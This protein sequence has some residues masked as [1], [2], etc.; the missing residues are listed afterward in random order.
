MDAGARTLLALGFLLAALGVPS[1][2]AAAYDIKAEL[3]YMP[4]TASGINARYAVQIRNAGPAIPG[5]FQV[6]FWLTIPEGVKVV[7]WVINFNFQCT[8]APPF[9]GAVTVACS[10]S[11]PSVW[12]TGA[13]LSNQVFYAFNARDVK[14]KVCVIRSQVLLPN[15][16]GTYQQVVET[17]TKNNSVCV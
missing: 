7:S 9:Q 5:P 10:V 1:G 15:P 17:D 16:A 4:A 14:G 6:K 3:T 11:F 12:T 13:I 8:P 2:P